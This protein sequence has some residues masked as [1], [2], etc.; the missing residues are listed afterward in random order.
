MLLGSL[1]QVRVQE[2]GLHKGNQQDDVHQNG[3]GR[4]HGTFAYSTSDGC[5]AQ[6]AGVVL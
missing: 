1:M 5:L 6:R 2:R 4:P 3:I